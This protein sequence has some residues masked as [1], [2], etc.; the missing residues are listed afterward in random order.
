MQQLAGTDNQQ[1]PAFSIVRA[2]WFVVPKYTEDKIKGGNFTRVEEVP[3][4]KVSFWKRLF[5][6]E[7]KKNKKGS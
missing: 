3:E 1:V 6:Q 7:L 4:E 2:N 5:R